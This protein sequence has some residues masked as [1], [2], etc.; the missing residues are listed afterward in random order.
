[1]K[2]ALALALACVALAAGAC[3]STGPAAPPARLSGAVTFR[4]RP[5]LP[6]GAVLTVRLIEAAGPGARSSVVATTSATLDGDPPFAFEL[7]YDPARL[8][9]GRVHRLEANVAVD[10]RIR[11]RGARSL[12]TLAA[13]PP[14]PPV[15]LMVHRVSG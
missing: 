1:M 4:E 10:D 13:G 3:R 8:Q 15:T 6:P 5:A 12:S 9:P 7:G 14:D 11:F 2:P